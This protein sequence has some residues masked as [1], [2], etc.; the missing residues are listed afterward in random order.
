M[1]NGLF[2]ALLF[3]GIW[4]RNWLHFVNEQSGYD[5]S[6]PRAFPGTGLFL[7]RCSIVSGSRKHQEIQ[8]WLV[9]V[10]VMPEPAKVL[11]SSPHLDTDSHITNSAA[12][13]S[14]IILS[15]IFTDCFDLLRSTPGSSVACLLRARMLSWFHPSDASATVCD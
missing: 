13:V 14:N 12:C 6:S 1:L 2:T 15:W 4:S 8:T 10:M 9:I 11:I 3:L 5:Q 7:P